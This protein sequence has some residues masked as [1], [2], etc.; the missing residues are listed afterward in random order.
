[1]LDSAAEASLTLSWLKALEAGKTNEVR[2]A[3]RSHLTLHEL[4]LD[5]FLREYP[6]ASNTV[7]ASRALQQIRTFFGRTNSV[8]DMIMRM[9][10]LLDEVS[11]QFPAE[12][13][14]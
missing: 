2:M 5:G 1:M 13:K 8:P 7:P 14:K 6:N 12:E 11:K 3:M 10:P 4:L 9:G